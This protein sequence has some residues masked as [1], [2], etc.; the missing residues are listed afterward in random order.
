MTGTAVNP[1][2]RA[3]YLTRGRPSGKVKSSSYDESVFPLCVCL[4]A[5]MKLHITAETGP[6]ILTFLPTGECLRLRLVYVLINERPTQVSSLSM[7]LE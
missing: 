4:C 7:L 1:L 3:A 2:L 5:F 6:D